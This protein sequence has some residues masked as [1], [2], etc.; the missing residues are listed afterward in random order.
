MDRKGAKQLH[1]FASLRLSGQPHPMT[2]ISTHVLD[3]A[4]GLP[5]EG[6]RITLYRANGEQVAQG[7]TDHDGR[8]P[9]FIPEG[10]ELAAGEYRMHFDTG[11]YFA[12]HGTQGFY[13]FVEVTFTLVDGHYHVPLLLSPWGFSTYRGS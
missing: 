12:K 10:V 11:G 7:A 4:R 13:P 9:G 5:A 3:T 8:I 6:L 2:T 1:F